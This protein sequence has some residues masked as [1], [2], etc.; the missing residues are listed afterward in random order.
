MAGYIGKLQIDY[1][2]P[3]LIGSTLYGI[4]TTNANYA[5]KSIT[6][7]ENNSGQ[8]INNNFNDLQTGI[9]IHIKFTQG[10]NVDTN[11][12]L[13]LGTMSTTYPVVG[14]CVCPPNTIISFTLDE[15]NNW[16]VNDNVNTEYVFKSEYNSTTNRVITE[17][18]LGT[19]ADKNIDNSININNLTSTNLPT[20]AAV[21]A[22]VQEQT[23]GISGLT[24]AMHFRGRVD[25][26]P[27]ASSTATFNE[28]ISGDVIISANN[29]EYVYIKGETPEE[30]EW[31]ELGD[32]S[33]YA[34][35][36]SISTIV[37]LQENGFTTNTLPHLDIDTINIPNVVNAGNA[38]ILET[39]TYTV[40]NVTAINQ[41]TTVTVANGVLTIT[42]GTAATL[43]NAFTIG[44]VRRFE[45][46]TPAQLGIPFEIGSSSNWNAGE[47]AALRTQ[48][49]TVVVPDS[50]S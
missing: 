23:G 25:S 13:Q 32:E 28:Y 26:V 41:P 11:I 45:T 49:T 24:G 4:C 43:G 34:L 17:S 37:G 9:T 31:I 16:I 14:K 10:N 38:A 47:Q 36:S 8:F 6:A 33:S 50:N 30:S 2:T 29:K 35:K 18:D 5:A 15:N 12:T 27:S 46:N 1:N 39:D 48:L 21:A 7:N 20:T 3:V 22:Y 44:S 42:P 19:A 40:P